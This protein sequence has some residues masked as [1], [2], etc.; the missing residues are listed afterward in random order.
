MRELKKQGA[1]PKQS[2]DSIS[3]SEFIQKEWDK[4]DKNE[5]IKNALANMTEKNQEIIKL[6]YINRYKI[7]EI[8]KLKNV[9]EKTV[10]RRIHDAKEEFKNIYL[11]L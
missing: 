10:S 7:K 6:K 4:D 5:K 8:A 1:H 2:I 3:E 11:T 9:S